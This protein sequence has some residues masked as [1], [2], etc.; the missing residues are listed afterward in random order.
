MTAQVHLDIEARHLEIVGEILRE[1]VPRCRVWA[2][3]SRATGKAKRFSDLDLAI[4]CDQPISIDLGAALAEAFSES[5]LPWK[6]D[7]VDLSTV[8]PSFRELIERDRVV[9]QEASGR[10]A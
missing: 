10:Q 4:E 9:I 5:D 6:V 3:G 1:H 2:F 8:D 7:I